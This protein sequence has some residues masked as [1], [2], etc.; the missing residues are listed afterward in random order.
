MRRS[1]F[2]R[3]TLDRLPDED[4]LLLIETFA[5]Q[6][7]DYGHIADLVR[8]DVNTLEQMLDSDRLLERLVGHAEHLVRIS[9]FFFF[10]VLLRKVLRDIAADESLLNRLEASE[11]RVA[12][13]PATREQ[14]VKFLHDR[15]VVTYLANMLGAF[16]SSAR[17][18]RITADDAGAVR[19]VVDM[20]AEAQRSDSERVFHIY[21][22]IG[23]FSLFLTGMFPEYIEARHRYAHRPATLA[24]YVQFGRTYYGLAS[25]HRFARRHRLDD[26]LY[27]LSS[28][29]ETWRKSLAVLNS[30]YL[31]KAQM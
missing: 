24:H 18:H 7:K 26:T 31:R 29:F 20:I 10:L 17:V 6:R 21:C 1:E 30:R 22:H 25:D 12:A 16:T 8:G 27:K 2:S 3:Y 23:N 15:D 11:R 13:C 28:G 5:T 19:Y 4:L 9:P 14:I